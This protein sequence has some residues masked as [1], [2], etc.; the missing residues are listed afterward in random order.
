MKLADQNRKVNI[1]LYVHNRRVVNEEGSFYVIDKNGSKFKI[2]ETELTDFLILTAN[3]LHKSDEKD[4]YDIGGIICILNSI[5]QEIFDAKYWGGNDW[6]IRKIV[7]DLKALL[8]DECKNNHT[9]AVGMVKNARGIADIDT[10]VIDKYIFQLVREGILTIEMLQEAEMFKDITQE[11]IKELLEQKIINHKML[12]EMCNNGVISK[13]ECIEMLGG[14]HD[15]IKT[16]RR[17]VRNKRQKEADLYFSLLENDD[18]LEL[19][20]SGEVRKEELAKRNISKEET[21]SLPEDLFIILLKKGLPNGIEFTSEELLGEYLGRFSGNTLIQLAKMGKVEPQSLLKLLDVEVKKEDQNRAIQKQELLNL[22]SPDL[23][24]TLLSNGTIDASFIKELDQKLLADMD[25]EKRQQY[26]NTFIKY[27]KEKISADQ[28]PRVMLDLIENTG[29][30]RELFSNSGISTSSMEEMLF[31]GNISEDQIIEYFNQGIIDAKMIETLYESDYNQL[32]EDIMQGTIDKR[33]IT[34]VPREKMSDFLIEGKISLANLIDFYNMQNGISVDTLKEIME[35]YDADLELREEAGENIDGRKL[36]IV[37]FIDKRVSSAKIREMFI[38]DILTHG[39]VLELR[40]R[41]VITEEQCKEISKIDR[42]KEY[43]DIFGRAIKSINDDNID[44]DPVDRLPGGNNVTTSSKTH[45]IAEEA[46][47]KFFKEL[48]ANDFRDIKCSD[49][50]SP[51]NGYTLIGFKKYGLVVFE[52]F[53]S[54]NNATYIMTLEELKSCVYQDHDGSI[55]LKKGKR[56]I[57]EEIDRGKAIANKNHVSY[58]GHNVIEAMRDLSEDANE[59]ITTEMQSRLAE[60]MI[61]E[62]F[63]PRIEECQGDTP[64]L[65]MIYARILRDK[66]NIA[67][68][69]IKRE[70]RKVKELTRAQKGKKAQEFPDDGVPGGD[71]TR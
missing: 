42:G 43:D 6:G 36:K 9:N 8:K 11:K 39:D 15:V 63:A 57:K 46:R 45:T 61:D 58:W 17:A 12:I 16:Y 66:R 48:G 44:T 60:M 4:F 25:D 34:I 64:S 51:F 47:I 54:P 21:R 69:L 50:N 31:D 19:Y 18:L 33:A 27:C 70:E 65:S 35:D 23:I 52:N 71:G 32:F 28:Y 62:Y 38:H 53:A 41:G 7:H 59:G 22:Y 30:P 37:D 13:K 56:A 3:L 68:Q 14:S 1:A 49:I 2:E 40:D 55:V 20:V 24:S 67:L 29:L 26:F 5:D 10:E